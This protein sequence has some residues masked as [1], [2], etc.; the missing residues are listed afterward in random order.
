MLLENKL[1]ALRLLNDNLRGKKVKSFNLPIK[2]RQN[3]H[4]ISDKK[5]FIFFD[6]LNFKN[7]F[8]LLQDLKVFRNSLLYI[9]TLKIK[10]ILF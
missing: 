3:L 10:C 7:K 8:I 9:Y 6:A 2:A 1:K 4:K 5:I